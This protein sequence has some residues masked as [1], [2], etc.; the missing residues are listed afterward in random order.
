MLDNRE[1]IEPRFDM[2]DWCCDGRKSHGT[3][4]EIKA[5]VLDHNTTMCI[6][7][8]CAYFGLLDDYEEDEMVYAIMRFSSRDD[9]HWSKRMT[10]IFGARHADDFDEAISR[11]DYAI[12]HNTY[13]RSHLIFEGYA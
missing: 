11:L 1:I 10:Y 5:V 6:G 13:D 8:W 12:E 3:V 7:G 4:G 2:T 9:N